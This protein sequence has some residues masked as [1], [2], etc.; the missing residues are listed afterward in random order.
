[1]GVQICVERGLGGIV[2]VTPVAIEVWVSLWW[3]DRGH[4]GSRW[5]SRAPVDYARSRLSYRWEWAPWLGAP[6]APRL[7]RGLHVSLGRGKSTLRGSSALII[8]WGL[9]QGGNCRPRRLSHTRPFRKARVGMEVDDHALSDGHAIS[10]FGG[11]VLLGPLGWGSSKHAGYH[12]LIF[13]GYPSI[14]IPNISP[15][16]VEEWSTPSE[17]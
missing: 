6:V 16:P 5:A 7:A 1:M 9:G 2:V 12:I 13:V 14:L 15:E 8:S 17:G 10:A 4:V 11:S 3:N